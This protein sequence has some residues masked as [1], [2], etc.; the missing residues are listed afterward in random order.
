MHE[1]KTVYCGSI[2]AALLQSRAAATQQGYTPTHAIPLPT[3]KTLPSQKQS[4][5]TRPRKHPEV[6]FVY[7]SYWTFRNL[8]VSTDG[9]MTSLATFLRSIPRRLG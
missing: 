8:L 3:P 4:A 6:R 2:F 9:R 1:M 5:A 7:F